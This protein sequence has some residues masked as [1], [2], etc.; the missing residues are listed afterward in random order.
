MSRLEHDTKEVG[1]M[2]M[3]ATVFHHLMSRQGS[4]SRS[5]PNNFFVSSDFYKVH[6]TVTIVVPVVADF[7]ED[8]LNFSDFNILERS[9]DS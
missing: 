4:V 7:E 9:V 8:G 6:P 2:T 5:V 1:R 3:W